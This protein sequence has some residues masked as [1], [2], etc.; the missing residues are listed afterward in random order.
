MM[1]LR[2]VLLASVIGF[3]TL[4]MGCSPKQTANTASPAERATAISNAAGPL[5]ERGFKAQ[6]TVPDPPSKLRAGQK[7]VIT[8]K[9]KNT[10]DVIWRRLGGET[11][12]RPDNKFYIAVGSRWLDK[13]GKPTSE[14]E[15]HNGMTKDLNPGEET[16]TTLQITAPKKPGE[17]ILSLDM[18]QEGVAWFGEKGSP[19]TKAKITVVK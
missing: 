14:A 2:F 10:S 12:N 19:T 9:V 8:L 3:V 4:A 1:K 16:E 13:D 7:E 18:V 5:V 15:G 6:I 17:Y 11:N